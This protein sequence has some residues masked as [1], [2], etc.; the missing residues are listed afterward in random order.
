MAVTP[1]ASRPYTMHIISHTH[2]DR[3]WYQEFQGFRKRLVFQ[4]DGLLDLLDAQADF[5][6]FHLDGQTCCIL[7]YLEIRPEQ[8][9]RLTR[10]LQAERIA[11]G[12]WFVMPDELILSGES[13]VRNLLIGHGIC[14]EFGA[15]ALKVGYVSDI[16]GH[17]SQFPQILRGFGIDCAYLHRGTSAEDETTEMVWEGADDSEVLLI[18]TL[19]SGGYA[20]FIFMGGHW[21]D[22]TDDDIRTYEREKIAMA[23]TPVLF[24]MSGSDHE[25]ARWETFAQIQ[26]A[27]GL[28]S[29]T[30]IIHSSFANYLRALRAA[31][32]EHWQQGRRRFK[33]ELRTP[34]KFGAWNEMT[35][36]CASSRVPIKQAND[37]IEW[38][39][40]RAADP[41]HTWARLLGADDQQAY[42]QH[43]W[44]QLILNHPHDSVVGCSHDQVH[45]DMT[46]RFD[47]ARL[48]GEQVVGEAITELVTRIDPA[49]YGKE[50]YVVTLF[51]LATTASGPLTAF[52]AEILSSDF[53]RAQSEGQQV[54]L[55]D[56]HGTAIPVAITQIEA[57][58][59]Q[60]PEM[61]KVREPSYWYR[62]RDHRHESNHRF[63]LIGEFTIPAL[64]YRAL[65]VGF[66]PRGGTGV[67]P[68]KDNLTLIE[69]KTDLHGRDGH[70]TATP[71]MGAVS[72]EGR[73]LAND[74]LTLT[75]EEN[76]C[77]T[78]H[79]NTTGVT[80]AHLH[81]FE[82]CGDVGTG[83]NHG[84]PS[85]D[86][87]ILSTDDDAR[88]P[89]TVE[90]RQYGAFAASLTVSI[91]LQIPVDARQGEDK[92]MERCAETTALA[93]STCYTLIADGKRVDCRTTV[94]NTARRHRL[95]ILLPSGRQCDT[96]FGDTA[97]DLVER[98]VTLPDT[99]GWKEAAREEAPI[100]NVVA[101]QDAG[102]GLAV[103]T[104]GL[105]EACVR[106]KPER[107]IAL[108]LFR[109]FAQNLM[110]TMSH[111]SL[112]L[113]EIVTEYALLPF[114]PQGDALGGFLMQQVDAYKAP[115]FDYTL[116][117]WEER[118]GTLPAQGQLIE[119]PAPLVLS[120]LKIA[121]DG[122]AVVLRIYNPL[123]EK[124][125]AS[126]RL[127]FPFLHA[128]QANMLEQAESLIVLA[129]DGSIPLT[130][131]PKKI[132]TLRVETNALR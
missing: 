46:Y 55:F 97:F 18:K 71:S 42:L 20:D 1:D 32:G 59:A 36:G 73:I 113:G 38:L 101:A 125:S 86:R 104:R 69:V 61:R 15:P 54:A 66:V 74:F 44:R 127:F 72:A 52:T 37:A 85:R 57:G 91:T 106:D 122:K 31:L 29:Q 126:L 120:T 27:L 33:G 111:D 130:V 76:G 103:L 121:E 107:P 105:Q 89:V 56:E 60:W 45:R 39:L 51:N 22:L 30:N 26:R 108:T 14:A 12:P 10:H 132:V 24:G 99:R 119:V 83:W 92:R 88:G 98:A 96:W 77:I 13:L 131:P 63:H 9:E 93:I 62:N 19:P 129:V 128:S 115:R 17:C 48:L 102:G 123:N 23:T 41:L 75:V 82:D 49:I 117:P 81:T 94:Q 25:P 16:F 34:A 35:T 100:K 78:L 68:V 90:A 7:D 65:R 110:C 4:M 3:E 2:W 118:G 70:A 47:Q 21:H 64:G 43:A 116:Y 6:G 5:V 67:P 11:I 109:S 84:Y 79:D 28:M 80:Y 53:E 50:A 8:R 40:A 87:R 114:T 124:V 58:I 112:L 95:R